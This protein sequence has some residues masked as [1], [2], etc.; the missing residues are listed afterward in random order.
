LGDTD[1][2]ITLTVALTSAAAFGDLLSGATDVAQFLT[3][4][5][6]LVSISQIVLRLAERG[7]AHAQ[8]MKRWNR[9]AMEMELNDAPSAEDVR[10]WSRER[11][12]IENEC[13]GELRALRI[14]CEDVAARTL[15]I[16][17]RQHKIGRLQR[18]F[19]HLGTFQQDF[20]DKPD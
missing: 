7:A 12:E 13:V 4:A 18:L 1:T 5:V 11:Y 8:W 6:A 15:D 16:K 9:L 17:G 10:A 3:A 19:I 14:D 2:F 20:P